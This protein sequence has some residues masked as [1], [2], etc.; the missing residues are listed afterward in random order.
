VPSTIAV[1]VALIEMLVTSAPDETY[2]LYVPM[3]A[4]DVMVP[5]AFVA[6]WNPACVPSSRF[7]PLKFVGLEI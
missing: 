6:G 4:F 1:L 7:C 3:A 5:A 2:V